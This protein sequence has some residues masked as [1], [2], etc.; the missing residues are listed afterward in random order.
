[1]IGMYPVVHRLRTTVV[2]PWTIFGLGDTASRPP[3]RVLL[4][5]I[6]GCGAH[7]I[8]GRLAAELSEAASIDA[9]VV[10]DTDTI[11]QRNPAELLTILT[12]PAIDEVVLVAVSHA[13]WDLPPEAFSDGGFER[14]VFV[15]PPDW[16]A[17][18]FRIWETAWGRELSTAELDHVVVATEGWAGCDIARLGERFNSAVDIGEL[19]SAAREGAPESAAWLD[20]ARTMVSDLGDRGRLDDLVGY[21]QRYRLL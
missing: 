7:F 5:G 3:R 12:A 13:P 4:Y 1:M 18:R 2:A 21:L 20:R 14:F 8:A 15:P 11:A 17:R 16:D 9:V 10:D 19:V 6:D